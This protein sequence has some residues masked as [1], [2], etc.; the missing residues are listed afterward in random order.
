MN[1][2]QLACTSCK[3]MHQ[4][5]FLCF[6]S[7]GLFSVRSGEYTSFLNRTLGPVPLKCTL[8]YHH[9]GLGVTKNQLGLKLECNDSV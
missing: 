4:L 7:V 2:L 1:G 9:Q 8:H 3:Q 5:L 6:T